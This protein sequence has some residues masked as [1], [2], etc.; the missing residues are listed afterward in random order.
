[1]EKK[2]YRYRYGLRPSL[3]LLGLV[4]FGAAEALFIILGI[5][6][7]DQKILFALLAIASSLFVI[8]S[9]YALVSQYSGKR[10]LIIGESG[11]ILPCGGV[12]IFAKKAI[13]LAYDEI[14]A[15]EILETPGGRQ[16]LFIYYGD[17]KEYSIR[18]IMLPSRETLGEIYDRI[19]ERTGSDKIDLYADVIA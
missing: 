8:V 2:I 10:Q 5:S 3:A 9:V 18:E 15:M 16:V 14:I 7:P 17:N 4:F 13:A 12:G 19:R 11:V 6:S 1:M